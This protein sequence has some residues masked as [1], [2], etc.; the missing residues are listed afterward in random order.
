VF[1][2]P[3]DFNV[4]TTILNLRASCERR[5]HGARVTLHVIHCHMRRREY[6][7]SYF[8]S[9]FMKFCYSEGEKEGR[10][11]EFE[12]WRLGVK[13]IEL[14]VFITV[15]WLAAKFRGGQLRVTM[16]PNFL[17]TWLWLWRTGWLVSIRLVCVFR[18]E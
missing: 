6:S 1:F 8:C 5:L 17:W 16:W 15:K 4:S 7:F 11:R 18:A 13:W 10:Q 3:M 2:A 12:I 14:A 9:H